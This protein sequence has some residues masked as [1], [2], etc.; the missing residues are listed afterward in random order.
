MKLVLQHRCLYNLTSMFQQLLN[1][2]FALP[3]VQ[4][5]TC[6]I[7][8]ILNKNISY[9]WWYR[10][11][12]SPNCIW[13]WKCSMCFDFYLSTVT[14]PL[15]ACCSQVQQTSLH[16]PESSTPDNMKDYEVHINSRHSLLC[17]SYTVSAS[18]LITST[19]EGKNMKMLHNI[20]MFSEFNEQ[21]KVSLCSI[22][23]V[24]GYWGP[25]WTH[26]M[27][28]LSASQLFQRC[29]PSSWCPSSVNHEWS[30]L[31]TNPAH[32]KKNKLGSFPRKCPV[33]GI[34]GNSP[35]VQ[36]GAWKFF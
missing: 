7:K 28:V 19:Q 27:P 22:F 32:H 20:T 4:T 36:G 12:R 29:F 34:H 11:H 18:N 33:T 35:C 15:C 25:V 17:L 31:P 23:R 1:T 8:V 14:R 24:Q 3:V 26:T 9:K 16:L 5:E 30:R 10:P 6:F 2:L 21:Y 13:Y